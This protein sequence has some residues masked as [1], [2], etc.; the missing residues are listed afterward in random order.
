MEAPKGTKFKYILTV[1]P[2]DCVTVN[3]TFPV[4]LI[5]QL[6][7]CKYDIDDGETLANQFTTAT[8]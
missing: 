7:C 6:V 5:V 3:V 2:L 8:Q 4:Q 1:A